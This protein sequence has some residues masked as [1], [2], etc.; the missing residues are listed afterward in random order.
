VIY[1]TRRDS[2]Q[3]PGVFITGESITN[4]ID[5]VNI[6]KISKLL[7]GMSIRTRRSM[8]KT[9]DEKSNNTVPLRKFLVGEDGTG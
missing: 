8:K 9:V 1:V 7:L 3:L 2:S 5:S 4:K 6:R